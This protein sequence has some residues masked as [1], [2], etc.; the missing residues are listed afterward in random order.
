MGKLKSLFT[1]VVVLTASMWSVDLSAQTKAV[2]LTRY[3]GAALEGICVSDG[4]KVE[5][6]QGTETSAVVEVNE[7]LEKYLVFQNKNGIV[8]I[9][10]D[11]DAQHVLKRLHQRTAPHL[12]AHVVVG[13]IK[14]VTSSSGSAVCVNTD[15]NEKKFNLFVSSGAKVKGGDVKADIVNMNLG[16]GASAEM[17]NVDAAQTDL[18][19]SS[20]SRLRVGDVGTDRL[21]VNVGSGSSAEMKSVDTTDADVF[22]SSSS[23]LRVGDVGTNRLNINMG[24]GSS[25]EMKSVDA[26]DADVFLFSSSRLYMGDV[27]TNRIKVNMGSG[28]SIGMDR[29]TAVDADMMA[30]SSSRINITSGKV[31]K[32]VIDG[33]SASRINCKSLS[34]NNAKVSLSSGSSAELSVKDSLDMA[35]S[36][37]ASFTYHG[38]PVVV[39]VSSGGSLMRYSGE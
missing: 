14:S 17:G 31:E 28:S 12:V 6:S 5:L 13:R 38:T 18:F 2:R 1:V 32:C 20:S 10:L 26:T 19:I 8:T 25:A 34:V 33:G 24:S 23:R 9:G 7:E 22:L 4:F 11:K 39:M 30:T 15:V 27:G 35:V 37:S 36:R 29:M 21:N 3:Q 16:A